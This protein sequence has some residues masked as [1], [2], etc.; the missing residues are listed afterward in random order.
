MVRGARMQD[1]MSQPD[2]ASDPDKFQRLAKEAS[3][4]QTQVEKF[5]SYQEQEESLADTR[6]LLR[7]S[8][9][10]AE[11]TEL[12]QQEISEIEATL[13]V[14]VPASLSVNVCADDR[15]VHRGKHPAAP[16][17]RPS[18]IVQQLP[19]LSRSRTQPPAVRHRPLRSDIQ[20]LPRQG[21]MLPWP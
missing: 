14:R 16:L 15:I 12:A 8:E 4:I 7:D 17:G 1:M 6:A 5:K 18:G 10:D 13:Q 21:R 11:M 19:S 2:V 9:G 3:T 20:P